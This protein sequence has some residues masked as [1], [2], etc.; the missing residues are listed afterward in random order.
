MTV[1]IRKGL[2]REMQA[3]IDFRRLGQD[4][5]AF[6]ADPTNETS[7]AYAERM[8]LKV[9]HT[10]EIRGKRY[11]IVRYDKTKYGAKEDSSAPEM[12]MTDEIAMLRS[13]I[14]SEGK[15]RCVSLPKTTRAMEDAPNNVDLYP[16]K[17]VL[18]EGPMINLFYYRDDD[19][20]GDDTEGQGWQISTRSVFGARNSFYDDDDGSKLTFRNM[21][22]EAM[23]D[24]LTENLMTAGTDVVYSYVI[25]HPKNRDVYGDSKPHL[26]KVASFKPR[27]DTNMV[28]EYSAPDVDG[29]PHNQSPC[30]GL[31][32]AWADESGNLVRAKKLSEDYLTLR[33]LRGTQPKLK[34]H[35]LTLRKQRGAVSQ[36][37]AQFPEHGSA[38][39]AFRDEIHHFT[40]QLQA[41][42][43]DCYVKHTK[44][45]KEYDGNFK[46]H[47]YNLHSAFKEDR[48]PVLI[49]TVIRYVN[50]LEPAQLMFA[51]N[52]KN[53]TKKESRRDTPTGTPTESQTSNM[54]Q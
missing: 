8:G 35:F 27:D 28:W 22:L 49:S 42:Y 10:R 1:P 53:R 44:P 21:F 26:V 54:E 3:V 32:S 23:P 47:M 11:H 33:K 9:S 24:N 15:I 38:F 45:L 25:R 19:V 52:W 39:S 2:R 18:L 29:P 20:K 4:F 13:V 48:K 46:T 51:L 30:M 34:Y 31:T 5:A 7:V 17:S 6:V 43:W 14:I 16:I 50:G 12:T 41:N 40:H 36:Y 37:L